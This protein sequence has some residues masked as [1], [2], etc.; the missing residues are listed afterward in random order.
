MSKKS[1]LAAKLLEKVELPHPLPE[2]PE[3]CTI[4]EAGMYA[5]LLRDMPPA[6]AKAALE[7]LRKAYPDYNE[8]RVA[9]AQE[10]AEVIAPKG[11]GVARLDKYKPAARLV[12]AY[13]K[14]VFQK[15]HGLDFEFVNEDPNAGMKTL[16]Q[17]DFIGTALAGYL[18]WLM[19]PTG[20]P[21]TPGLVR[22]LDRLGLMTRTSSMRKAREA[23]D[24]V[25]PDKER[26]AY[27]YG[28]GVV[29]DRWCGKKPIC[30]ECPL[31]DACS[32]GKKIHKDW[33]VQQER[34]EKQRA[35]EDAR[36]AIL[37]KKEAARRKRDEEREAKRLEAE[38]KKAEREAQRLALIA[39]KVAEREAAAAKK[40]A[41]KKKADEAKKKAAAQKK[42]A[43]KK[44]APKKV[45]KKAAAKK[46]A[47]KKPAAKKVV[48]K[49]AKKVAKKTTTKKAATTKKPAKKKTAKKATRRR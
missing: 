1:D 46:P 6:R 2:A 30:W 5:V 27:A 39:K 24:K 7:A 31:L 33:K 42:A 3:G 16:S 15:S 34:L 32:T 26:L 43:P 11:K 37:E 47:A 8:T 23:L 41:E 35:K 36:Q 20:T 14:E 44:A 22:T 45:A 29:A 25:V 38:A 40:A 18:L 13:L 12:Q 19:D 21:A 28:F 4:L 10:I 49:A 17:M 9:Q 48:K